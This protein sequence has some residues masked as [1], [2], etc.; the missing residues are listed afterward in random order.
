MAG[1]AHPHVQ[2]LNIGMDLRAE[3][4]LYAGAGRRFVRAVG[5]CTR[6]FVP[7]RRSCSEH[8]LR[9]LSLRENAHSARSRS[10]DP[11]RKSTGLMRRL[12]SARR[13]PVPLK[14][15]SDRA[16]NRR[17]V[18]PKNGEP[19]H[20]SRRP[21]G[22]GLPSARLGAVRCVD[23]GEIPGFMKE[24]RP[25]NGVLHLWRRVGSPGTYRPQTW[26]ELP[27]DSYP[28]VR[29]PVAAQCSAARGRPVHAS[30]ATAASEAP[31]SSPVGG[32]EIVAV[33]ERTDAVPQ[34]GQATP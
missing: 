9:F 22:P 10:L 26:W 30:L 21:S 6:T 8:G 7:I 33:R 13:W 14:V 16:K 29:S 32:G 4:Q 19:L 3:V 5:A 17:V 12:S 25:L 2:R 28:L 31:A 18:C 15:R 20:G 23:G 24:D 27:A 1:R 11:A 34:A